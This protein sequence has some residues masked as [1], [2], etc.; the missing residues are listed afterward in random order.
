MRQP[1]DN[2]PRNMGS[3]GDVVSAEK[4]RLV[5]KLHVPEKKIFQEDAS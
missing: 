4:R 2:C 5:E 1:I 3:D